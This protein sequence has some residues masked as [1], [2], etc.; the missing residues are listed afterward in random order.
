MLL[1]HFLHFLC[2]TVSQ[3]EKVFVSACQKKAW[4]HFSK[5]QRKN[6]EMWQKQASEIKATLLEEALAERKDD[7]MELSDSETEIDK[8][9]NEL[10]S[11]TLAKKPRWDDSKAVNH[12]QVQKLNT[13]VS[14]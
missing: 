5:A 1:H 10:G 14:K 6:I 3:I 8:H 11:G 2:S 12:L 9:N 7:D 4:D 13:K